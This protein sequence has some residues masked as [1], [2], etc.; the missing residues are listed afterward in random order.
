MTSSRNRSAC[1]SPPRWRRLPT[2]FIE[3]SFTKEVTRKPNEWQDDED[4]AGLLRGLSGIGHSPLPTLAFPIPS[5]LVTSGKRF[6]NG[7]S[8]MIAFDLLHYSNTPFLASPFLASSRT[9]PLVHTFPYPWPRLGI[10]RFWYGGRHHQP[11]CSRRN[12]IKTHGKKEENDGV[13]RAK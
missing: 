10:C 6:S 7:T 9:R 5:P 12:L 1:I 8:E 2:I 13:R 11:G 4:A 3:G